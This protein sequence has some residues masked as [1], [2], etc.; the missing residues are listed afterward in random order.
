MS[1]GTGEPALSPAK[2]ELLRRLRGDRPP[3]TSG[4]ISLRAGEGS[5][6]LV[7]V[8]PV[9]GAL[10]CYAPLAAALQA[11]SPVY[12]FADETG[13]GDEPPVERIP[14]L[15][16]QYLADLREN[17]IPRPWVLGGWSFGGLVAYEMARIEGESSPVLLIDAAYVKDDD[18]VWSEEKLRSYFVQDVTGLTGTTAETEDF[19][20]L[21]SRAGLSPDELAERYR[22][23]HTNALG[24][25]AYRPEPYAGPVTLVRAER[26][27]D[28][29]PDWERVVSGPLRSH[30]VPGDHYH[31]VSGEVAEPL[32]R[33][34]DATLSDAGGG[35]W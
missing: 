15:A 29:T 5:P 11:P 2:L 34:V 27:P 22:I 32:A 35:S 16:E 7:L 33:I 18:P 9:G 23:F 14:R 30:T 8:H 24:Q 1:A 26:S 28:P 4:P 17:G 20:E 3:T 10:F 31:V 25:L 21:G 19:E 13:D 6:T 12:G